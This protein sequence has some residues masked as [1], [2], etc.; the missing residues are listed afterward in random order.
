MGTHFQLSESAGGGG[1]GRDG[2]NAVFIHMYLIIFVDKISASKDGE[3]AGGSNVVFVLFLVDYFS[4]FQAFILD[5]Q[6]MGARGGMF[7]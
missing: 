2:G 1:G 4:I 7:T 5:S 6:M 3:G